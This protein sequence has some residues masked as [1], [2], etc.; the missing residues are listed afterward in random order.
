MMS[1]CLK[2]F[3]FWGT[4]SL[5]P[6]T[7]ALLL[8]PAGGQNPQTPCAPTIKSWLRHCKSIINDYNISKTST[9]YRK[10][11]HSLSKVV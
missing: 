2:G 9:L 3:S 11:A 1:K 8:D 4:S 10:T 6:P 5:R 7:G